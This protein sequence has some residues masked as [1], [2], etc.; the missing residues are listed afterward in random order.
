MSLSRVNLTYSIKVAFISL[1][2]A[3]Y[4]SAPVWAQQAHSPSLPI[5][6]EN[7]VNPDFSELRDSTLQSRLEAEINLRSDW[8]QLIAQKKMSVSLVDITDIENPS[9][10]ALNGETTLYA[11]SLPKIGILLAAFQQFHDGDIDDTP[12]LRADLTRMIRVSSN[13][14]ATKV[15]DALGGLD[16]VNKVL[17]D[18]RYSLY[19]AQ[20]DGGIWVGKRYAKTGPRIGDPLKGISHAASSHQTSR[21]YYLLATGQL[22]SP[23]ASKGMLEILCE[24]GINH[25]FVASLSGLVDETEM[26]RKSGS[27]RN[28]HADSVL[29]W[30]DNR[31]YILVGLVQSPKGGKILKNLVP[32][33]ENVLGTSHEE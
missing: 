3:G 24:P 20:N 14:S 29:V 4:L 16:A 1:S 28:Y 27:W 17:K 7:A 31:R 12:E 26:F 23:E 15:V 11:A 18:P 25:K 9:Y 22:V 8:K 19:D 5:I 30:D 33:A 2:A 13:V 21:F 10:A 6:T 32:V